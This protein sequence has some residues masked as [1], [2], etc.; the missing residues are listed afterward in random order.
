MF[1]RPGAPESVSLADASFR[2]RS[3]TE[4]DDP[5]SMLICIGRSDWVCPGNSDGWF[6]DEYGLSSCSSLTSTSIRKNALVSPV[7]DP[8]MGVAASG[9]RDTAT[10]TCFDPTTV[11]LVGSKPFHPAPGR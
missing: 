5:V 10:A 4:E 3:P 1:F 8:A 11:P 6:G 2:S 7:N 9:W